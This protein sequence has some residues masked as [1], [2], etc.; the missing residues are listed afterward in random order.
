MTTAQPTNT[1]SIDPMMLNAVRMFLPG[2]ADN[3]A[4]ELAC[5]AAGQL[6]ARVGDRLASDLSERQLCEFEK[7]LD[8]KDEDECARWLSRTV[9]E[10][11]RIVA[12]ERV[13][14]LADV[15][16]AVSAETSAV[17]GY[18]QYDEI[19]RPDL[20]AIRQLLITPASGDLQPPLNDDAVLVGLDCQGLVAVWAESDC[21]PKRFI[22]RCQ[23]ADTIPADAVAEVEQIR[24][25]WNSTCPIVSVR[26]RHDSDAVTLLAEG[27]IPL[28]AGMTRRQLSSSIDL[29]HHA[30]T[31]IMEVVCEA[32]M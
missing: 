7:V 24:D 21:G 5:H 20:N 30:I 29:A 23:A 15:V 18:R 12:L 16:R 11:P 3:D 14:V 1:K 25:Q 22:V 31:E 8:T 26:L 4:I 2:L 28:H 27:G 10:Y 13:S 9:P 32:G 6:E 17:R 19:I